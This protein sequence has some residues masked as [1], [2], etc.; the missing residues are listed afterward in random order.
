MY[1]NMSLLDSDNRLEVF[2]NAG[3]NRKDHY[4]PQSYMWG[5]VDPLREHLGQPLWHFDVEMRTWKERSTREIGYRFGFYDYTVAYMGEETAD[6]AFGELERTFPKVREAILEDGFDSWVNYRD[7][8]LSYAQMMRAR[9]LL[10]FEEQQA[11]GK[12]LRALVVEKVSE[13][14]RT[15]H[16]KSMTPD[17][18]PDAFVRNWSLNNMRAEIEKGPG[19]LNDFNWVLRYSDSVSLPFI[20]SEAAL[21][22]EGH[23]SDAIAAVRDKD[24]LLFFPLCWQACLVG[25]RQYITNRTDKFAEADMRRIQN[26]FR[27][28]A[29]KFVL[30]PLPLS[31]D[32]VG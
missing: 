13:D 29:R 1:Y 23:H 31:F 3:R 5:F 12:N 6:I 4:I 9:S 8:L 2:V 20:V 10:F 30:A 17:S 21:V 16:V 32:A 28:T 22:L 11:E 7:F 18:L 19:W 14:R 26:T 15:I 25:S 24:A 27:Q